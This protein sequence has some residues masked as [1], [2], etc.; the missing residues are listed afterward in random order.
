MSNF[1]SL[2]H[3]DGMP[4]TLCKVRKATQCYVTGR[5]IACGDD[6]YR[7]IT[8]GQNR[9]FRLKPGLHH[10]YPTPKPREEDS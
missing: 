3:H 10:R 6:A 4:W 1:V 2:I 9:M 8:N 7:P 5:P